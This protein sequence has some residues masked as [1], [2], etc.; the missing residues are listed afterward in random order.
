[1]KSGIYV[2]Q[3][4]ATGKKY[5]G[6][7]V[8]IPGRWRAHRRALRDGRHHS[9]KLQRAWNK[10]S[11]SAFSFD[12]L[13]Y[14]EP[15]D[16]LR[17]EQFFFDMCDPSC[18][19]YNILPRAGSRFGAKH[20]EEVKNAMR[21]RKVSEATKARISETMKGMPKSP[22]TRA[23]MRAAQSGRKSNIDQYGSKNHQAKLTE[24]QVK[25]IRSYLHQGC[26]GQSIAMFMA[27]SQATVSSIKN[28][29]RWGHQL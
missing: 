8:N 21:G 2:I 10:Y 16:L 27:I 15:C 22:E 7:S 19:G 4:R 11:E 23:R 17:Q 18:N 26:T 9:I 5:I 25:D 6:S 28:G 1:M 20:R 14:C 12:V 13:M 29:T 24:D 3:N